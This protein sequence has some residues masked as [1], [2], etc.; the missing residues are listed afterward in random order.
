MNHIE[1]GRALAKAAGY[2]GREVGDTMVLAWQEALAHEPYPE[3]MRAVT[4]HYQESTDFLMPAQVIAMCRR[5]RN[6]DRRQ[7]RDDAHDARLRAIDASE[8]KDRSDDIRDLARSLASPKGHNLTLRRRDM[9]G[10]E[11]AWSCTCGLNPPAQ[12]YPSKDAAR[13]AGRE[14]IPAPVARGA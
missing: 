7:Q 8:L 10:T 2:D 9:A 11:W 13:A 1:T 4:R 5:L 6:E 14:H 12:R 3:V